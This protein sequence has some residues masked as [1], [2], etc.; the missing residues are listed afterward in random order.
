MLQRR[1]CS[2]AKGKVMA[3]SRP[4][5]S[6][7]L[8]YCVGSTGSVSLCPQLCLQGLE[9]VTSNLIEPIRE[10]LI[11]SKQGGIPS[12]L[13]RLSSLSPYSLVF[14]LVIREAIPLYLLLPLILPAVSPPHSSPSLSYCPSLHFLC[15]PPHPAVSRWFLISLYRRRNALTRSV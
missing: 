1:R 5:G 13:S 6:G 2:R 15:S 12:P 11:A 8:L 9:R 3:T 10:Q 7:R 14:P 4:T